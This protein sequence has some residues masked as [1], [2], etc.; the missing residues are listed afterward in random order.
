MSL[1]LRLLELAF[2]R[3]VGSYGQRISSDEQMLEIAKKVVPLVVKIEGKNFLNFNDE[4]LGDKVYATIP[5]ESFS[6]DLGLEKIQLAFEYALLIHD[7]KERT[8]SLIPI[9][10]RYEIRN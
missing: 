7:K 1:R 9:C 8:Q 10:Y 4:I 2:E 5:P 3:S 6:E